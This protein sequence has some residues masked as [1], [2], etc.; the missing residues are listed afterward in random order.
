MAC[1]GIEIINKVERRIKRKDKINHVEVAGRSAISVA[2][3]FRS[4]LL[5]TRSFFLAALTDVKM[6]SLNVYNKLSM[7]CLLI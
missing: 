5:T 1:S 6:I 3:F 7:F 2:C 4:F